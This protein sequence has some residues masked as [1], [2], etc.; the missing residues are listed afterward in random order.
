VVVVGVAL[1]AVAFVRPDSGE[2]P[3]SAGPQGVR[4]VLTVPLGFY[5]TFPE[6]CDADI[7]GTRYLSLPGSQVTVKDDTGAI[8]A[9]GRVPSVGKVVDRPGNDIFKKNCEF[10]FDVSVD[11]GKNFYTF[12]ISDFGGPT[13][14]RDDLEAAGWV[15]YMGE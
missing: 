12:E 3:A 6:T 7:F 4:V 8:I 13:L 10:T 11:R 2:P 5:D 1:A 15:A 9:L 14:S